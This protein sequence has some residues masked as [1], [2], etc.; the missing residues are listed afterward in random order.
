MLKNYIIIAVRT[1]RRKTVY[2]LINVIGLA[3]S[4]FCLVFIYNWV[5]DELGYDEHF[6]N[7][8]NIYRVV[9][10]AG[11]GDE[12]WHQSVTSLPLGPAM[13]AAFPEVKAQ[14]RLAKNDALV[15]LGSDQYVEDYIILTDPS[16][17]EVFGYPLLQGNE[18][19]ALSEPYQ[20]VLTRTMAQKYFGDQ[21]PLGQT[22]RIYLYDPDG[23]GVDYKITGIIQDPPQTSHFTYNML[24]SM[25]TMATVRPEEMEEWGYNSY[26]TYIL[27][28][29][30]SNAVDLQAKLPYL[31]DQ[32][33]SEMIE[34]YD[35]FYRFYLQSV[36][37]IHLHSSLSYEF[38][39]NGSIEFVWI[40]SAIGLLILALASINY[41]NLST[42]FSLDRI[43]EMGVRKSLGA[44]RG[45]LIKQNLT[46]T[47]LI[48]LLAV[49]VAGLMVE[50]L[51]PLFYDITG[52]YHVSFD[53]LTLL[54]QLLAISFPLG[55]I[56]GY[57]PGHFLA[58][59]NT[60]K[61]LKGKVDSR[62][63]DVFRPVLV[64][65]Q[66]AITLFILVGLLV[67]RG[68]LSYVQSK[69]LGYDQNNLLV[70]AT[71]GS[72]EVRQKYEIF[73]NRLLLSGNIVSMAGSGSGIG[74]GL[75]NSNARYNNEKGEPNFLKTYS[76]PVDFGYLDTYQMQLIS[77]RDFMAGFSQDSTQSFVVNQSFIRE[78][79]W[80]DQEALN[81]EI[82]FGGR[83]G[84]II[85]VVKD[86]HFQS[87]HG[88]VGPACMY[89]RSNFSRITIRG[90]DP[91]QLLEDV[92]AVWKATFP[93]ALFYYRFQDDIVIQSYQADHRF[94]NILNIFTI[95]SMLIAFMGLYGLIGYSV[96]KKAKEIGIRKVLGA[97][98]TQIL[99]LISNKFLK[100]ILIA[101]VLS[102]PFAWWMM[103][104]WLSIFS[105]RMQL[106]VW[107]F[108]VAVATTLVIALIVIVGQSIKP[109]LSNPAPALKEE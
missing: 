33:M 43:K 23:Q 10:E 82:R 5:A 75:G 48:G 91:I 79:G 58:N 92:E 106:S 93:G 63:K 6:A 36:T 101:F 37:D 108:I 20:L 39:A 29:L 74:A 105:Y 2:S 67:V 46:E 100:M 109:S 81:K 65:L 104:S 87:L 15:E 40:F 1:I 69:D 25:S 70:L 97:T 68:Q 86:F 78:M 27:T 52:K 95:L 38:M 96:R 99:Q 49:L 56:S 32:H 77:G 9:A 55:I 54:I 47:F 22:L 21:N 18:K 83:T 103:D 41:I 28:E 59:V 98:T 34:E 3:T 53:R 26:Y 19:T 89:I 13:E 24:V 107:P 50:I 94:A 14:V 64:T 60:I 42:A 30:G 71:N 17:F 66:F 73:K 44:L 80:T 84:Q 35:L 102:A 31:V 45:Q 76:L 61:S 7:K 90:N 4:I 16:F 8:E 12:R 62:G 88:A 57:V 51:K 72:E 11:A 85:G